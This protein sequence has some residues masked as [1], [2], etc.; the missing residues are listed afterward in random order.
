[1]TKDEK[2]IPQGQLLYESDYDESLENGTVIRVKLKTSKD[3]E[4]FVNEIRKQLAYMHNLYIDD[5]YLKTI[6]YIFTYS[7]RNFL[8]TNINDYKIIKVENWSFR[9]KNSPVN[10]MHLCL[11]N[12][13]YTIDWTE[14][15]ISA[16]KEPVA[17]N[18]KIGELEPT[19][20]RESIVYG[21]DSI[22]LILKRIEEVKDY[23]KNIYI[24]QRKDTDDLDHFIKYRRSYSSR[25]DFDNYSVDLSN[26][27]KNFVKFSDKH[28]IKFIPFKDFIYIPSNILGPFESLKSL[29]NST[30][31]LRYTKYC[32]L[33][34][35]WQPKNKIYIFD[36]HKNKSFKFHQSAY[37][38]EKVLNSHSDIKIVKE[39]DDFN[40]E[41]FLG[42]SYYND[43]RK[44][45]KVLKTY[46][47][48]IYDYL[49]K[50]Q[51]NYDNHTPDPNWYLRYDAG[52]SRFS[53]VKNKKLK[54]EINA[55][56]T[57]KENFQREKVKLE[58]LRTFSGII[59][60]GTSENKDKIQNM[61]ALFNKTASFNKKYFYDGN[62]RAGLGL[63][64]SKANYKI[65]EEMENTV[66][67][68]EAVLK[69]NK[70]RNI[71]TA[72]KIKAEM[73]FSIKNLKTILEVNDDLL[74]H[75][76]IVNSF[77]NNHTRID[78]P[79]IVSD[80]FLIE[81]LEIADKHN[82]YND[83]V[84]KSFKFVKDYAEGLDLINYFNMDFVKKD[85]VNNML[86]ESII[87]Y[88][89]SKG[90]R[91]ANRYYLKDESI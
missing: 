46:K 73:S 36:E 29:S 91:I 59:I 80:D 69:I 62:Y 76:E 15:G 86:P 58:K 48:I 7:V 55:L 9:S 6:R 41:Q 3:I 37:I 56:V 49:R 13:T 28:K 64:V 24:S 18:F 35:N 63:V 47:K 21:K 42:K 39:E 31:R 12:I 89:K 30:A 32:T 71:V 90:K 75:Y 10:E 4:S 53:P 78:Y 43:D 82:Y 27:L 83:D 11:G 79:E 51:F 87:E 66:N 26:L 8:D 70:F 33:Y 77:I 74:L 68:D 85:T 60:Y 40:Y 54:G 19:P 81:L 1:M 52:L 57:S 23:Y 44:F 2:G 67:V 50:N 38:F 84:L 20:S 16:I 65:L 17:L 14:L 61:M 34:S 5:T 72:H 25:L 88:V 22:E 45:E